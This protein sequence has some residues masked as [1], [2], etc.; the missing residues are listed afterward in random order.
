[1]TDA[2]PAAPLSEADDKLWAS[3]SH[4]SGIVLGFVG[5][6]VIWLILKDRGAKTAVEAKE[7][8]NFQITAAFAWIVAAIL[9]FVLIGFLLYP[10]I[11]IAV[12]IFSILGFVKVNGGG[13]Y[14][15]PVAIRLVK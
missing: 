13:S 1:M 12:L 8:L 10:L 9:T 6:L 5:P 15:Y 2:T 14:R 11:G 7:A 4:L 3:L